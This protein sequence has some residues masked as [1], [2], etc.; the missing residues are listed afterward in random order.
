V[1]KLTDS[2]LNLL[3]EFFV[4]VAKAFFIGTFLS[5]PFIPSPLLVAKLLSIILQ[6]VSALLFLTL[7][8]VYKQDAR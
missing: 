2:Q 4:D 5:Q 3:S 8:L 7:A 6:I 1:P